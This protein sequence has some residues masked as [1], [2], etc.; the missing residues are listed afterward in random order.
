MDAVRIASHTMSHFRI[1]GFRAF[2]A[3]N[4]GNVSIIVA[5]SLTAV[6][7]CVGFGTEV[8]L[9]YLGQRNM[10]NAADAAALAAATNAGSN[11]DIEAK[12]VAQEYGFTDGAEDVEVTA[13]NTASC[14]TGESDCY[15]VTISG[16][17]P[18][19]LSQLDGFSGSDVVDGKPEQGLS[20]TAVA[21]AG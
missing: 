5:L 21:K 6:L 8:G 18:L 11:Y 4:R 9:W 14:P 13:S 7:G 2:A 10:Q 15:S 3:D 17:V 1:R 19:F 20:A 16:S 12:A